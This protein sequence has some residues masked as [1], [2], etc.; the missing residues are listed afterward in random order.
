MNI[1]YSV[2]ISKCHINKCYRLQKRVLYRKNAL[3]VFIA[4]NEI[5]FYSQSIK[6]KIFKINLVDAP[7]LSMDFRLIW[8]S[9]FNKQTAFHFVPIRPRM[10]KLKISTS[11]FKQYLKNQSLSKPLNFFI[12]FRTI[13]L[14]FLI[15]IGKKSCSKGWLKVIFS[16]PLFL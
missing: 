12:P 15:I 1:S 3:C 2:H 8:E 16:P 5:Y 11:N 14:F 10:I 13:E 9:D 6:N 4:T 7:S